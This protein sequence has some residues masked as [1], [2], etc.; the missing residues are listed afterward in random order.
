MRTILCVAGAIGLGLLCAAARAGEQKWRPAPSPLSTIYAEHVSPREVPVY[1][2]C[3][4]PMMVRNNN[5][6]RNLAGLWDFA[7]TGAAAAQPPAAYQGRIMAPF[8]IESALSGVKRRVA[9]NQKLWYR[10]ALEMPW[11]TDWLK[12]M[13]DRLVLRFGGVSGAASVFVNGQP[14]GAHEGSNDGF[15]FDVTDLVTARGKHTVQIVVSATPAAA[16]A[17]D[18]PATGIFKPAWLEAVRTSHI[19][20][21]RFVPDVD[22][23]SVRVTP[24]GPATAE[25]SV[26]VVVYDR[27]FEVAR[28]RGK[29]GQELTLR[30]GK[31]RAWTPER[32]FNYEYRATLRRGKQDLDSVVGPLA[33][34]KV[35]LGRW[36]SAA[37]VSLNNNPVFLRGVLDAGWWP[38]GGATAPGVGAIRHDVEK[39][40]Q[41]GFNAVRKA[42]RTDQPQWY[43]LAD[44]LGVMVLQELPAGDTP[45]LLRQYPRIIAELFNHPSVVA[46]VLPAGL[47]ADAARQLT[48]AIREAD[49][50]R[51]VLGGAEGDIRE[52]AMADVEQPARRGRPPL[53]RPSAAFRPR[54]PGTPGPPAQCHHRW[55]YRQL[56]GAGAEDGRVAD[57]GGPGRVHLQAARRRRRRL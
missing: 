29:M 31:L 24:G 4:R 43:F 33:V 46:W 25:D 41:L 50:T 56:P 54:C 45:Q 28:G 48:A 36:G 13:N 22:A 40:K 27:G 16:P 57:Q 1:E 51:L 53:S 44:C 23:S 49:P 14:V 38:D 15:S 17:G 47:S 26:E 55:I 3:L 5:D 52:I 30:I 2:F 6:A 21:L 8:P 37:A 18:L 10:L 42:F 34:R 11:G 35:S 9:P 39:I 20:S 7:I 19:E 12:G 32:P